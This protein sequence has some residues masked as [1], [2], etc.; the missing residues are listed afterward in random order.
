MA[1]EERNDENP[2]DVAI[3]RNLAV[4]VVQGESLDY[5]YIAHWAEEIGVQEIWYELLDTY[6]QRVDNS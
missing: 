4:L 1:H 6:R 3:H 2:G 5:A